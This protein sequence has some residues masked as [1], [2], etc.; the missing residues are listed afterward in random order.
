VFA[1][2][3]ATVF[4]FVPYSGAPTDAVDLY[5]KASVYGDA[6]ANEGFSRRQIR[7][8]AA[9]QRP[10]STE[11]LSE[12]SGPPAWATIPSWAIVGEDDRAIP[13]ADQIAMAKDAG[14]QIVEVHAPHL[15]MLTNAH[16]VADVITQAANAR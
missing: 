10:L 14:A 3:P 7:A 9:S 12:P 6:L 2:D 13:A 5:V 4:E 15:S 16:A 8:L 1:A 11:A